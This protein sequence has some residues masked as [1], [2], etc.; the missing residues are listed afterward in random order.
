MDDERQLRAK[1]YERIGRSIENV[2]AS[3][4]ADQRRI[5]RIN[6]WRGVV[7]GLGAALGGSLAVASIIYILSLFTELPLI[8]DLVQTVRDSIEAR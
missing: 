7:F 8:G 1:D 5:Y 4:Y 2:V 6:F 3:G